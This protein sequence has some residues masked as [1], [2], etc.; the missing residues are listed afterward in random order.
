MIN[1][2]NKENKKC[3]N[4]LQITVLEIGNNEISSIISR[5]NNFFPPFLL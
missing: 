2:S 4:I 3:T 1:G 5:V